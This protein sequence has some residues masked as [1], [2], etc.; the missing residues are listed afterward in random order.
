[1]DTTVVIAGAGPTGLMLACELGLAGVPTVVLESSATPRDDAPAVAINVGAVEQLDRRG[2]LEPLKRD[3]TTLPLPRTHFALFPL[4]VERLGERYTNSLVVT[5]RDLSATLERRAVEL[6]V[7][8]R[9]DHRVVGLDQGDDAV[10]VTA[11]TQD[12]TAELTCRYLVGC[13]GTDSAVR[14]LA[15]IPF[16]VVESPFYGLVGDFAGVAG[17]MPKEHLGYYHS[18]A[19]GMF[20][21]LPIGP[22]TLRLMTAE[23][24]RAPDDPA[25]AVT[26][27]E[28]RAT[29]KR[30][31]GTDPGP[32]TLRW[33]SRYRNLSGLADAYRSG[34]VFLAGD[35][36]H[37]MFPLNGQAITSG[38][39]DAVN[40]GWK[41]AATVHGWAAPDLLDTYDAERRPVGRRAC[42]NIRAQVSLSEDPD[43]VAPLREVVSWLASFDQSNAALIEMV[44]GLDVDYAGPARPEEPARHALLGRALPPVPLKTAEG[45]TDTARLNHSGHGVLLDLS[46]D[47]STDWKIAGWRDRVDVVTAAPTPELP[48]RALLLRPDGHVAWVAPEHDARASLHATLT[49]W[50]GAAAPTDR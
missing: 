35:S 9:R 38:L 49:R 1:M 7:T 21:C 6:G 11:R 22:D 26:P 36:A 25:S 39:H 45:A 29:V 10:R 2:L 24:D 37:A 43:R 48:A 41:L 17:D 32:L 40:L 46:G 31:S 42:V 5:Q 14:E 33:M 15:G 30:L 47:S 3:A 20:M 16:P 27:E 8:I 13:D 50:F 44:M 28:A 34:N 18:P 19:G 4:D 23:F 12:G